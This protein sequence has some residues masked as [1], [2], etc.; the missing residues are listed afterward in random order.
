[1]WD[2]IDFLVE[3]N[4]DGIV[5]LGSTGEFVHFSTA[6]RMRL[7]GLA[8]KRSRV[9]V[10]VNVSYSTL[11]GAIEM[12]QAA[13]AAGAAGLLLMP[14]YFFRYSQDSILAFFRQFA[15]DSGV[16]LPVLLYNIPQ[17]TNPMTPETI[18][19][20]LR[21]GTVH[22][23]KDSSGN[24]EGMTRL[25]ALRQEIPF[26]LMAGNDGIFAQARAAGASGIVSGVASAMP[27]LLVALNRAIAR[28][29][30][31]TLPSRLA[32]F[33]ERIDRLPAPIGIK[34]AAALRKLKVGPHAVPG[35]PEMN[36]E[37]ASFREWFES[38]LP[39]V[40]TECKHA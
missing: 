9:P 12:A 6:E 29:S 38:W 16:D 39:H 26:P 7:I 23:I 34:E 1:M 22:G 30:E 27:E 32:E 21:E 15:E 24:S 40:L 2:L 37:L 10:L 13:G 19:T 14:P 25:L 28:G 4:V 31:T 35:S 33:I 17:F 20:L 3:R 5:L 11:D 8:P 18:E 36:A